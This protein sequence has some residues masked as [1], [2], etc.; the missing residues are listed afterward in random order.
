MDNKGGHYCPVCGQTYFNGEDTHETCEV[1]DWEDSYQREY[2][3]E[4][5][6]D[7]LL[8]LNSAR[9]QFQKHG[10]VLTIDMWESWEQRYPGWAKKL[11]NLDT[12]S[13]QWKSVVENLKKK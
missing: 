12:L 1:C 3:D 2:P 9:E 5:G 6:L 11:K 7:N 8:S 13:G 10:T 4:S